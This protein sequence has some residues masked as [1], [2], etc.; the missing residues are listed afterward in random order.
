MPGS[1]RSRII[2]VTAAIAACTLGLAVPA[3]AR[4]AWHSCAEQG[5]HDFGRQ[6][7][8][9]QAW[10]G[11]HGPQCIWADSTRHWGVSSKQRGTAVETYPDVAS[12]YYRDKVIPYRK[13]A[14]LRSRYSESMPPRSARY[15]AEAAYD[16]WVNGYS[17][18]VMAWVDNHRQVPAG[19][20]VAS[21]RVY[22]ETWRLWK[23]TSGG[24]HIYSFVRRHS[25]S[26]RIVH[27]LSLLRILVHRHDLT[28][29]ATITDVQAGWEICSTGGVWR[30]FTWHDYTLITRTR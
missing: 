21:Y 9:N 3:G 27:L 29:A 4:A 23:D 22:G 24:D 20:V 17:A 19:H 10:N 28:A 5:Q 2:L 13:L 8:Q 11:S 26:H 16:I 6:L 7:A 25:F 14:A 30:T 12:A 15:I 18:E 1:M